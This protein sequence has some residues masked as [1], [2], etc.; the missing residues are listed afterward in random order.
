MQLYLWCV[1]IICF[2]F[3]CP[4][5]I[6]QIND[7]SVLYRMVYLPP[8]LFLALRSGSPASAQPSLVETGALSTTTAEV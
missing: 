4:S 3:L 7:R 5:I 2:M 1:H 8:D 6:M